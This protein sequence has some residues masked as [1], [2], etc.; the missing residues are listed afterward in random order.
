MPTTIHPATSGRY[1]AHDAR[2]PLYIASPIVL[3][4][5]LS[6]WGTVIGVVL[7]VSVEMLPRG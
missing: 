3:A 4:L 1:P 5:S 2:L 7:W 6:L